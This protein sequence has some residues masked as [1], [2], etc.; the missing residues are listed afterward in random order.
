MLLQDGP[1]C[2]ATGVNIAFSVAAL[3]VPACPRY[4]SALLQD[5]NRYCFLFFLRTDELSGL[6]LAGLPEADL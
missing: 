6:L 1:V 2:F 5:S 3:F 4:G